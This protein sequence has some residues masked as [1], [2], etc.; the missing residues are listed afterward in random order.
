[1]YI[2]LASLSQAPSDELHHVDPNLAL[3]PNTNSHYSTEYTTNLQELN[4]VSAFEG[5]RPGTTTPTRRSYV[6][7]KGGKREESNDF[8]YDRN[9]SND[10]QD[11]LWLQQGSF[12]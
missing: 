11:V 10:K 8:A 12:S 6:H 2:N 9:I 7:V 5:S 1:M 4:Y 3:R